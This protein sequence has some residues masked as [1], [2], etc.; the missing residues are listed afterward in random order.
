[1]RYVI[2][3]VLFISQALAVPSSSDISK[4]LNTAVSKMDIKALEAAAKNLTKKI[5]DSYKKIP[6]SYLKEVQALAKAVN[7]ITQGEFADFKQ[8]Q[9]QITESFKNY[10]QALKILTDT[11]GLKAAIE[12]RIQDINTLTGERLSSIIGSFD[13]SRIVKSIQETVKEGYQNLLGKVTSLEDQLESMDTTIEKLK[14]FNPNT[15]LEDRINAEAELKNKTSSMI[16]NS[17]NVIS[18]LQGLQGTLSAS[19]SLADQLSNVASLSQAQNI[20]NQSGGSV[21]PATIAAHQ[22]AL[23]KV[24]NGQMTLSQF[25]QDSGKVSQDLSTEIQKNIGALADA[26]AVLAKAQSFQQ[27]LNAGFSST[28]ETAKAATDFLQSVRAEQGKIGAYLES[29]IGLVA[30][31]QEIAQSNNPAALISAWSNELLAEK[32]NLLS[33]LTQINN[34]LPG[35]LQTFQNAQGLLNQGLPGYIAGFRKFMDIQ[36]QLAVARKALEEARSLLEFGGG[37]QAVLMATN[38]AFQQLQPVIACVSPWMNY[39]VMAAL[40]TRGQLNFFDIFKW[41][42]PLAAKSDL[43]SC[44]KG[45]YMKNTGCYIP[46]H[47]QLR[48]AVERSKK[49][50]NQIMRQVKAQLN[51]PGKVA[52]LKSLRIHVLS[53]R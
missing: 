12:K 19:K 1:M 21:P 38:L 43:H 48:V 2:S 16:Q 52:N 15:S 40:I 9:E 31:F 37:S 22:E 10:Q 11:Q 5:E 34:A 39:I 42:N 36:G 47:K 33:Q 14:S 29:G 44:K 23:N 46:K 6:A 41:I 50:H 28:L 30:K 8:I 13:P 45:I 20:L 26:Q 32:N 4:C 17:Q 7:Q 35:L 49:L 3:L 18:S 53:L 24:Q 25:K 51:F 27:L